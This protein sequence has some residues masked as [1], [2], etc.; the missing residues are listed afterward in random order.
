MTGAV[1]GE[2]SAAVNARG[3][4]AGGSVGNSDGGSWEWAKAT[5]AIAIG[6]KSEVIAVVCG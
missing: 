5:R 4:T 3:T 1:I 6:T 2:G